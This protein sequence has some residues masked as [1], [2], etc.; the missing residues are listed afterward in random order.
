MSSSP[1]TSEAIY[2]VA[3]RL[4]DDCLIEDGSL[5]TPG[6]RIWTESAATEFHASISAYDSSNR[7]FG[8]KLQD[9]LTGISAEAVQFAAEA[10]Y[11]VL[12]PEFDTSVET[13]CAH[14]DKALSVLTNPIDIPAD[15]RS[16]LKKGFATYGQGG[17]AKRYAHLI[18]LAS[19][20]IA[21]KT[22][23]VAGRRQLLGDPHLL[24]TFAYS[25]PTNK[26]QMQREA[27]LHLLLP[28][29]F[30]PAVS[31]GLKQRIATAFSEHVDDPSVDVDAQL[32]TI[33]AKLSPTYTDGFSFW[34]EEIRPKWDVGNGK[35]PAT[36]S[37]WDEFVDWAEKLYANPAFDVDERE[38]K[39][40][41]GARLEAA[42]QALDSPDWLA[43]LKEAFAC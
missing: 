28:R 4:R 1:W 7:T 33:R 36:T 19:F 25:L 42:R 20:V 37:V 41:V 11:V 3:E 9:Q 27:L 15:L 16:A 12:L 26:G 24:R 14:I 34:D 35:S 39:V 38:Y 8:E 43:R 17:L 40:R 31:S 21:L 32:R 13:K 29:H 5:F 30:E 22:K 18:Y 6:G 23:D 10:L 2:G